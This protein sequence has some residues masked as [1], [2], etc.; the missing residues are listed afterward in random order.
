MIFYYIKIY[1]KLLLFLFKIQLVNEFEPDK[2]LQSDNC[3]HD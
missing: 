2:L 1:I 3:I